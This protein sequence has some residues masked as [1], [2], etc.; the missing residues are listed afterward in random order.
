MKYRI[1]RR[2]DA[3]IRDICDYIARDNESVADKLDQ[4]LHEAIQRLA[5][6]PGL[7]HQRDDVRDPRYRWSVGN[8][9]IAYRIDRSTLIVLRV[10][11]GAR[12]FRVLFRRP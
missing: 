3:D 10:V 8:F 6:M 12:N 1:S 2:A 7:G 11:H 9:V 5:E 4:R